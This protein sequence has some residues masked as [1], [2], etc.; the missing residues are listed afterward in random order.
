MLRARLEKAKSVRRMDQ[1]STQTGGT[2]STPSAG[3]TR[4]T[5]SVPPIGG[6]RSTASRSGRGGTRPSNEW[7]FTGRGGTRPSRRRPAHPPIAERIGP[8][9]RDLRWHGHCPCNHRR[10]DGRTAQSCHPRSDSCGLHHVVCLEPDVV[11]QLHCP[12]VLRRGGELHVRLVHFPLLRNPAGCHARDGCRVFRVIHGYD[13]GQGGLP[14]NTAHQRRRLGDLS[15]AQ[16][17]YLRIL[18]LMGG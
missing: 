10:R 17:V 8:S 18:C 6:T 13:A 15:A 12:R 4:S 5:A 14:W 1:E 7:P 2:A 3:G 9:H 16:A 11:T